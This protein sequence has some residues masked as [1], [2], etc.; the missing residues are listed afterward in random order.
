MVSIFSFFSFLFVSKKDTVC[1][2]MVLHFFK[3]I[4]CRIE[5][6]CQIFQKNMRK[7]C[8]ALG[9]MNDNGCLYSYIFLISIT[10]ATG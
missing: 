5:V 3:D 10:T 1:C 4:F 7:S 6:L 9:N 8:S 2:M